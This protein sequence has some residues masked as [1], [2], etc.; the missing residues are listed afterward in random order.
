[1]VSSGV[2]LLGIIVPLLDGLEYGQPCVNAHHTCDHF[3][4]VEDC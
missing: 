3:V 2:E 1:M 4:G